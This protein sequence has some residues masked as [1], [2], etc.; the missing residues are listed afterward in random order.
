MYKVFCV[1]Y[2]NLILV[3]EV[4]LTEKVKYLINAGE[5]QLS[6]APQACTTQHLP[7]PSGTQPGQFVNYS[8]SSKHKYSLRLGSLI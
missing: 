4:F 5:R 6:S 1:I 7:S 2:L 8:S 3:L